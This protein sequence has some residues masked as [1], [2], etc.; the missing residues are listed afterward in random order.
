MSTTD[1]F[2]ASSAG[3]LGANWSNSYSSLGT[4]SLS[5]EA[6][7]TDDQPMCWNDL[8]CP[9]R[10]SQHISMVSTGKGD[11]A[12][13]SSLPNS[14]GESVGARW[15][16]GDP[17]ANCRKPFEA[18]DVMQAELAPDMGGTFHHTDCDDPTL[19]KVVDE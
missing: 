13:Y 12:A 9:V 19:A 11:I 15:K 17:C 14:A 7:P 8:G 18:G 6:I 4:G 16:A 5:I 3:D 2:N 10:I 1:D